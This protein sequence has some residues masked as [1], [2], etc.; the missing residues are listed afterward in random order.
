M[1]NILGG[2]FVLDTSAPRKGGMA[3]IRRA[4]DSQDNLRTVAIKFM[5]NAH[6]RDNRVVREAFTRELTALHTL[7]HPNVVEI[8]DF[9]PHHEPPYMVLEWLDRDLVGWMESANVAGWD[10]FF[11]RVGRPILAGLVYALTKRVVHRDLKPSNIL[12][13]EQGTMKIAD[14]GISKVLSAAPPGS[15][16]LASFK[17]I[18][19][20]P[21][22]ESPQPESRDPY[23]FAVL[24]LRC[25]GRSE[26]ADR[27]QVRRALEEFN[28]PA[29][30]RDVLRRALA[31][32]PNQRFSSVIEL[33]EA[34]ERISRA[35]RVAEQNKGAC[36][37][38]VPALAIARL[39]ERL[40]VSDEQRVQ[41]QLERD[42][43][44]SLLLSR[45]RD[46]DGRIAARQFR[47]R[48]SGFRLHL[49]IDDRSDD[50]LL[51]L[52]AW[53]E[54]SEEPEARYVAGLRPPFPIAFGRPP[55][56]VDGVAMVRMLVDVI[57]QND[58]QEE[59]ARRSRREEE[60]LREWAHTLRFRQAIEQR[61][62][63]PI[64]Y[65]Q[66]RT[67]GSRIVFAVQTVPEG[68]FPDQPR[69]VCAEQQAIVRGL[70]DDI[71]PSSIS[72]W[73]EYGP[74]AQLPNRGKLV[75]D[76]HASR[77][78][79][80]RQKGAL[81]AVRYGR[82]VRPS[83][84]K[85]LIDP[86]TVRPPGDIEE[87][88][89]VQ[90]DFDNDKKD[91]VMKALAS[92]EILV[93]QGPPGTGKTRFITELV[94]HLLRRSRESKILLTSQTHVAL[95]NALEQLHRLQPEAR[96][97]RVA[98]RD[99]ERVSP[100][101]R[102]L[103]IERVARRWGD[104]V[105]RAS[106]AFLAS[107]AKELG[108]NRQDIALGMASGRLRSESAE[109]ARVQARITQ[110]EQ[111]IKETE[112]A[113]AA[114]TVGKVADQYNEL[115]EAL[116]EQREELRDLLERTRIVGKS[117]RDAVAELAAINEL[118]RQ[119]S[120]ASTEDLAE[121]EKGMLAGT[122]ADRKCHALI[123]LADEWHVRFPQ[124]RE[125]YPAMVAASSI[126][127]G[128]CLGFAR[129]PGMLT[130]EFDI[131]IVDEAS[132]ATATEVLVPLSRAKKWIL[133]G[134]PRQLPPFVEDLLDDAALLREYDLTRESFETTL[135]DRFLK[136]LPQ[137]CVA[138]LTT[139]HRMVRPIGDLVSTCFYDGTLR[140]VRNYDDRQLAVALPTPVTWFTTTKLPGHEETQQNG[141]IKNIAE[142]RFIGQWLRR[143]DFV[144]KAAGKTLTVAV[145]TGYAGQCQEL[146][147]TL[148]LV[149]KN[150][151]ALK[152]ECNTVD[153]FQGREADI[154]VYSI[155]RSNDRKVI[156][157]LRD[158]RRMNVALS[159][160]RN[161][162]VI[163]GDHVFC[164][165]ARDPN[166]LR[167]VL[168]YIE[169]HPADCTIQEA[170]L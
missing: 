117:R 154:C 32:D 78:A 22:F 111:A 38:H 120:A 112:I 101:V 110:C 51:V 9:D 102:D 37:V 158:A 74:S 23:S 43:A 163:V 140:S 123:R 73:V 162:L 141:T 76:D 122:D 64:E 75:L 167:T 4:A 86:S 18:P 46:R 70:I 60:I 67:D 36:Y 29:E 72:L 148:A 77:V 65:T 156:G 24:S 94:V 71:G 27:E 164:R 113:L 92:P 12:V 63:A 124:S 6:I 58:S 69:M 66:F 42:I 45:W 151:S 82:C 26:L 49:G 134:D 118:G 88:Q 99:D 33:Q 142:A 3:E 168:E 100:E 34:L 83:L 160:G 80:D 62:F 11:A 159:R 13:D 108:V 54:E 68:V 20:A 146:E 89:W 39:C 106:E 127:A 131:C 35:A 138:T 165:I 79:L 169:N 57:E 107:I 129:V 96:I 7:E 16:T 85:V 115:T 149:E 91:A 25:V 170:Q 41:K 2:R 137:A 50:R 119:L 90:G 30:V 133:V 109:L 95:D 121:W 8:I 55:I 81:D 15:L 93:V 155:T 56:G 135:L 87:P 84:R 161:G 97:L 132:K 114:A 98:Q 5:T 130:A 47:G 139:Q 143:L 150:V 152:L 10:D 52:N 1:V 128:T 14:F 31:D 44:E 28:G 53:P 157:F 144:A 17:S 61:R 116:E 153:A 145:I 19:Y 147:R 48:T 125:F 126:V 104:D 166:P 40:Q 21:E 59:D 136:E 105:A 103:T